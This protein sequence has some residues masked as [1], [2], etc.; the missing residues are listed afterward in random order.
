MKRFKKRG[1][2]YRGRKGGYKRKR[3]SKYYR[4]PRGGIRM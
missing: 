1:G 4:I 3:L 2:R